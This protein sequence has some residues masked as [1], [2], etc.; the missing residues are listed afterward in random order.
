M[1]HLFDPAWLLLIPF[2]TILAF[3][4]WAL[5]NFSDEIR[6]GRRRR[7]RRAIQGHQVRIYAPKPTVIRFRRSHDKEAA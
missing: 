5:W 4:L 3:T 7:I 1:S 6:M 2:L